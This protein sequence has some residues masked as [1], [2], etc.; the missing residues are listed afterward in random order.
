MAKE[1][2]TVPIRNLQV[3]IKEPIRARLAEAAKASGNS[4]NAEILTRLER[5]LTEERAV[6]ATIEAVM[7]G[8]GGAA[9]A[10]TFVKAVGVAEKKTGKKMATDYETFLMVTSTVIEA[11]RYMVPEKDAAFIDREND[12]SEKAEDNLKSYIDAVEKSGLSLEDYGRKN[13]GAYSAGDFPS[14][15]AIKEGAQAGRNI[16]RE[17]GFP[18]QAGI[19]PHTGQPDTT[20]VMTVLEDFERPKSA[21][22]GRTAPKPEPS[23]ESHE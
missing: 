9:L 22:A 14:W 5:S 7:G 3:R 6:I 15:T 16:V 17:L 19:N 20:F 23:G 11:L 2:S 1:K 21:R 4:M 12:A 18:A 10:R 13:P 8:T